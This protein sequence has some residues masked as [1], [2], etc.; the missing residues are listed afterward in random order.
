MNKI[1]AN[2]RFC[3][4]SDTLENWTSLNPI[5]KAGEFAVITDGTETEKVK[6][7]D[8][9]TDFN[10][11]AFWKGE[12][13]DKG[14]RG[15]KGEVV[16]DQIF[17]G[18]SKNPQSGRAVSQ[19][20]DIG[21]ARAIYAS[22]N[23]EVHSEYFNISNGTIS[24]KSEYKNGGNK[25]AELPDFLVIP[26]MINNTAVSSLAT[27]M[28]EDN[29][30]IKRVV[31]PKT[32]T[33]IPQKCFNKTSNLEEVYNTE[34]ITTIGVAAFQKSGLR[35]ANFPNLETFETN[36]SGVSGAF[37]YCANLI[38]A[39]IGKVTKIPNQTFERCNRLNIVKGGKNVTNIGSCAFTSTYALR[40]VECLEKVTNIGDRAFLATKLNYDWWSR[41]DI[42][43]SYGATAKQINTDITTG[44]EIKY[45]EN[46]ALPSNDIVNPIPTVFCQTD[47]SVSNQI[48]GSLNGGSG[49]T[50]SIAY[51][52][53]C[54][55]VVLFEAYCGL[56]N[57]EFN[58]LK[59]ME[60][61]LNETFPNWQNSI[62]KTFVYVEDYANAIGLKATPFTTLE[63]NL[64]TIYN[65]L[66]EG[67]YV[68]ISIPVKGDVSSTSMKVSHSV[69]VYGA[70]SNGELLIADSDNSLDDILI[71]ENLQYAALP[72]T[73]TIPK[74]QGLGETANNT[75]WIY[76]LEKA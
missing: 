8:G 42:S 12:K 4:R 31:L 54:F 28:F 51:K 66:I 7:G 52:D 10:S 19:A 61:H 60:K 11:L 20:V 47:P 29:L 39:D 69:L 5:L 57:L 72:Q 50:D 27:Q 18:N 49:N 67:K 30:A 46:V 15:N 22:L 26:D 68:F 24:L 53:G 70:K 21:V 3:F 32:V 65:S 2:A 63:G 17:D 36:S 56:N 40:N 33:A 35:R 34:Q 14:D 9:V 45:W 44:N 13:G 37:I 74:I 76:I 73:L 38:Y 58:T 64:Q 1:K 75:P 43:Y 41:N 59:E 55:S 71:Y 48:I 16:V 6:I 62:T 25:N 23:P